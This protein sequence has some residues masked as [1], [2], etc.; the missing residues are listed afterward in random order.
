MFTPAIA[1]KIHTPTMG[2]NTSLM[3]HMRHNFTF[4][5]ATPGLS[6]RAAISHD[7]GNIHTPTTGSH[8]STMAHMCR[9]FILTPATTGNIDTPT[10]GPGTSLMA[11]MRHDSTLTP[12]TT[13]QIQTPSMRSTLSNTSTPHVSDKSCI[14]HTTTGNIHAPSFESK[15]LSSMPH[16]NDKSKLSPMFPMYRPNTHP[17]F[18]V[19]TPLPLQDRPK[20]TLRPMRWLKLLANYPDP[21]FT[22]NIVGIATHGARIG[23]E[24]PPLQLQTD[25]HAS[26]LQISQELSQ[27]IAD[28]LR[29]ARICPMNELPPNYACSP[30]GATPKKQNGEITRWRRIH[31]LSFPH[32][33]S[34]NDGIPEHYR[35][36]TYQTLDDAIR[37]IERLGRHTTLHKRD[38]RDAFR[39]IPVSP[40]DHFLLLFKW[41]NQIYADMFLP[42]GLA[43]SP[44]IFNMFSEALH[45]ILNHLYGLEV[46]HYLDDFLLFNCTRKS[47]FSTVCSDVG[48][49]EKTNKSLDG[50][51][52]DFIGIELDTDKLEARLPKDKHDRAIKAVHE[53]LAHGKSSHKSLESLLG[54]LSFCARVIPLGRPFLRNLFDF[55]S[56]LST[57]RYSSRPFP[58]P[59]IV[60]LRWWLTLL[61]EW[62]GIRIIRPCRPSYFIYTDA[63]GK[64]GIGGW[65]GHRAFSTNLPRRHMGKHI[66][67]KEAYA[68]LYAL[69]KWAHHLR[70][71]TIIFMCDNESVVDALSKHT[72]RGEA[73]HILQLIYLT[74]ALYDLELSAKWLSSEENWIADAL[75]R[76]NLLK[77]TNSK[78]NEVF[79][80]SSREPDEP[81][82]L[83]RQKLALFFRTD[84][85]SLQDLPTMPLGPNSTNTQS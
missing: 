6:H 28:E 81:I 27:N 49:E 38:L 50:Y 1:G 2:S 11:H 75:S 17:A 15:F 68:I 31:D 77:L 74:A 29:L 79:Q 72:I 5:P 65:F 21:S 7:A 25:N 39:K 19:Y 51:I 36:L 4:T 73:I 23:Y 16:N 9:N 35:S 46:V 24:G 52:V 34:V 33:Y 55:L 8:T 62:N 43:T 58:K 56:V 14:K 22:Q 30:L 48:F 80:I 42:F 59:A 78:L 57:N 10:M 12:A 69:S 64:K 82:R 53:A 71:C 32:G 61:Q 83:L 37:I 66:N 40:L 44:F 13:G 63:S 26:A 76:F 84:L 3:A 67:W 60:D 20:S 85:P 18:T 45:W 54:Y 47:L 41:E 70:G